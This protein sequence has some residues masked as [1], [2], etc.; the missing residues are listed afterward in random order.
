MCAIPT[1]ASQLRKFKE[2]V[3]NAL[4]PAAINGDIAWKWVKLVE[5]HGT[6]IK[7]FAESHYG[8]YSTPDRSCLVSTRN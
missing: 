2:S 5:D 3:R 6:K 1:Q 4:N 8:I 7:D